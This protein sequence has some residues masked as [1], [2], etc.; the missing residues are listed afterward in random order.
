MGTVTLEMIV[1][2]H[3]ESIHVDLASE[4][5]DRKVDFRIGPHVQHFLIK[6]R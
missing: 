4:N 6:R 1:G 5:S 2:R 3:P